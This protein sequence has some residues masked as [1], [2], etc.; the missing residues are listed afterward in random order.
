V[1]LTVHLLKGDMYANEEKKRITIEILM[2]KYSTLLTITKG[3][4]RKK[5]LSFLNFLNFIMSK[6]IRCVVSQFDFLTKLGTQ[7]RPF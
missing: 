7:L 5:F 4:K 1:K 6:W 3:K 2:W